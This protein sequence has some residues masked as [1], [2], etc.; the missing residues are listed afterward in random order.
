MTQFIFITA[1][2]ITFLYLHNMNHF[3]YD[4]L[5]KYFYLLL[6]FTVIPE[7]FCSTEYHHSSTNITSANSTALVGIQHS[8]SGNS[9]NSS[10]MP[11]CKTS[12]I[13][14]LGSSYA[15]YNN[16]SNGYN[17]YPYANC[18]PTP[19]SGATSV[20]SQAQYTTTHPA[21][22]PTMVLYPQVYSTVNQ[23]QIHLH[24]HG[25]TDKFEP[26]LNT[27]TNGLSISSARSG[28]I[29]IGIGTTDNVIMDGDDSDQQPQ[30]QPQQ[31]TDLSQ[32]SSREDDQDVGVWRPYNSYK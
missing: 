9:P 11:V 13:D 10:L 25:G 23:N 15:S 26:Y 21:T 28:G 18:G 1:F 16:W 19:P 4:K 32:T 14:A 7:T 8:A 30:Q 29:E 27:A 3:R 31:Q 22:A 2:I 17:N 5:I 12:E 6:C 20:P 24:L